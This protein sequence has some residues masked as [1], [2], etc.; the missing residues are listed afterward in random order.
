VKTLIFGASGQLGLELSSL[1][2]EAVKTYSSFEIP[3]GVKLDIT[4]FPHLEDLILK[5]RPGMVINASAFTDV[6]GCEKDRQ[7][8]IKVNAEAVKH[9]VRAS[10]V[11]EAYVVHVSTDYVFDGEKGLY[12]EQDL[13]NPINYYGLSKLLGEAYALSYDD[14]LVVRTSGVFRHKGFPTFVYKTLK[15]GSVVN[16]YKGYYSPISA[17]LLAEAIKELTEMRKTGLIHVAGER[18]S[19]YDLALKV[20]ELFNLPK[21][22]KEVDNVKGWIAK[23]PFDSSL[24]VTRA[25]KLLSTEFYSLEENL[26]YMVVS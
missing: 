14:S 3:G 12:S 1:F 7:K 16:A 21:L 5:V 2:P 13:P 22:V 10:R 23:R 11:V 15:S 20:G 24:D 18:I 26:K 4:D 25:R 9:I 6:D 19:R 17:R 8:A